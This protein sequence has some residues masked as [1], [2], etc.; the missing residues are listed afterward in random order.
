MEE[1]VLQASFSQ[2]TGQYLEGPAGLFDGKAQHDKS[3][4]AMI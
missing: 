2:T 1:N 4:A 3:T